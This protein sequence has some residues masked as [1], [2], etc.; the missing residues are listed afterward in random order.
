MIAS[1]SKK[2]KSTMGLVGDKQVS[3]YERREPERKEGSGADQTDSRFERQETM[4]AAT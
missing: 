4:M 2:E 3:N 1:G